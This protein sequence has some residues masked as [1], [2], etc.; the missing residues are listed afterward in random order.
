MQTQS[1]QK[2]YG[3]F[4][5]KSPRPTPQSQ[6]WSSEHLLYPSLWAKVRILAP[7]LPPWPIPWYS[8]LLNYVK[9]RFWPSTEQAGIFPAN[10]QTLFVGNSQSHRKSWRIWDKCLKILINIVFKVHLKT[11]KLKISTIIL[12]LQMFQG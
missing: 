12:N 9:W 2:R 4:F 7:T 11:Y 8:S 6:S 5:R 10:P 3:I 1:C